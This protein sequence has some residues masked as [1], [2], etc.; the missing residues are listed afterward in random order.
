MLSSMDDMKLYIV[1]LFLL[2][3]SA[4]NAGDSLSYSNQKRSL[5]LHTG[6]TDLRPHATFNVGRHQIGAALIIDKIPTYGFDVFE[7]PTSGGYHYY[8]FGQTGRTLRG[9][10]LFYRI[11]PFRARESFSFYIENYLQYAVS[12]YLYIN[13]DFAQKNHRLTEAVL[14][15]VRYKLLNRFS[16][17]TNFG[18]AASFYF[19]KQKAY[20]FQNGDEFQFIGNVNFHA[21]FLFGFEIGLK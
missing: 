9:G 20:Q 15:G 6:I 4:A 12:K 1:I 19:G 5:G 18:P 17:Y 16:I 11:Y 21:T 8:L 13:N 3:S 2:L 7:S 10:S 14:V